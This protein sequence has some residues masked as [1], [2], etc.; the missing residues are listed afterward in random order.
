[1]PH[2]TP[3]PRVEV[4][5]NLHR[6]CWSVRRAGGRVLYHARAV[7]LDDVTWV[8]QPAGRA[9]VLREGR[10]NVHAFARGTLTRVTPV[11]DAPFF[12]PLEGLI[13]RPRAWSKVW[14]GVS[15]NPYKQATF[16]ATRGEH[17]V[18]IARSGQALMHTRPDGRPDARAR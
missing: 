18:P 4:Y 9:R 2:D 8:V 6:S 5:W 10:K 12:A 11:G 1:M 14:R 16:T 17:L 15:Y 13:T 3:A 7:T